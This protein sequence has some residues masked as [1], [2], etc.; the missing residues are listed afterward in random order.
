MCK[1]R[2]GSF[3]VGMVGWCGLGAGWAFMRTDLNCSQIRRLSLSE[4]CRDRQLTVNPAPGE[5]GVLIY[6]KTSL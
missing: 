6:L 3:G 4:M 1:R 2:E 5:A